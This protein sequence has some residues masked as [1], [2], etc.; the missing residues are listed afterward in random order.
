MAILQLKGGE[1]AIVDED[2]LPAL[3]SRAWR[4]FLVAKRFP[5]VATSTG[6]QHLLHRVVTAAPAGMVVDHINGNTLDNR[7]ANLRVC[8]R[9]ENLANRRK[10]SN[11]GQRFK[12][13][14]SDSRAR[15]WNVAIGS[16]SQGTRKYIGRYKTEEEAAAM[17][18]LAA[19]L[20]F[21]EFACLNF[22]HVFPELNQRKA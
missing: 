6:G 22:P 13:I 1:H 10:Q 21:G 16:S 5:Y 12:G 4:I 11:S 14:S 18:D 3:S 17:Y 15:G 2:D 8:T 20:T 7:K 19:V 9:R